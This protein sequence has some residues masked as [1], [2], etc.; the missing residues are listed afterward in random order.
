MQGR[1]CWTTWASRPW[2]PQTSSRTSWHRRAMPSASPTAEK[3]FC[4]PGLHMS[5]RLRRILCIPRQATGGAVAAEQSAGEQTPEE[6]R[7]DL[8]RRLRAVEREAAA[9]Q[10]VLDR[11]STL[12]A[13]TTRCR[14]LFQCSMPAAGGGRSDIKTTCLRVSATLHANDC[15][16]RLARSSEV[17]LCNAVGSTSRRRRRQRTPTP[18]RTRKRMGQGGNRA[19]LLRQTSPQTA[20]C[21]WKRS[22]R[23]ILL[24]AAVSVQDMACRC[25]TS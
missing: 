4:R 6:Q 16:H 22:F 18:G 14:Q 9:V 10:T 23:V 21:A 5:L 1:A 17:A 19:A 25:Q 15:M 3:L 11:C 2:T 20:W 8:R 12:C 24:L 13:R 7:R